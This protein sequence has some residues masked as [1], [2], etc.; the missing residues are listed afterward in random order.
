M[1]LT[2]GL[3]VGQIGLWLRDIDRA[4][5]TAGDWIGPGHRGRGYIRAALRASHHDHADE[6]GRPRAR[7][8]T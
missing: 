1:T 5:A 3:S 8:V 4:P 7:R 6:I 2:L